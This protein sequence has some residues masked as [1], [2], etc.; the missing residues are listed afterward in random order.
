VKNGV[1]RVA[2]ESRCT[3]DDYAAHATL[4][5]LVRD[6]RDEARQLA[7]K[8]AGRAVWM[9]S[10]TAQG[11]GVAEMMPR[12]VALLGE[13]GVDARWAVMSAEPAFFA[14]TKTIHN[15]VHGTGDGTALGPNERALYEATSRRAADA[16]FGLVAPRDLLVVHDPQP[17]G[18]GAIVKRAL[19]LPAIWRCHIG[20][21]EETPETRAAWRFLQPWAEAYDRAVFSAP[22]FFRDFLVGRAVLMHPSIDP[23]DHKNRELAPTKLVGILA[24]A[25]LLQPTHPVLTAPFPAQA[26]RLRASDGELV[27]ALGDQEIG[28]PFRPT[29]VQISRWDRLKGFAPLI[30]G[31]CAL[32][33]RVTRTTD[34]RHRR[35]LEIARLILAGPEPAAIQDDP[36]ARAVLAELSAKLRALPPDLAADV[37][38]VVLPMA[39]RK[40]N[41]LMVNCLQRCATLVVQNS[42][43]EGF[44]LTVTEA[45]WKGVAVLGTRGTGIRQQLRDRL[46]G[47][48]LDDPTDPAEIA[49]TLDAMLANGKQRQA[50]GRNG[51]GRVYDGF[52]VFR[53]LRDWLR[54]LADAADRGAL[55]AR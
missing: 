20:H 35:R 33:Q 39:S 47:R 22:E 10:S 21:T 37:A 42:L 23:L 55:S 8:L 12:L 50:W 13:L 16:L 45:M 26:R 51:H 17:L 29:V 25:G 49:E 24:N 54:L 1:E 41:A 52:L 15:L 2:V 4:S 38:L 44:S 28:Q 5:P 30:D 53:Q 3:L 32:K 43:R 14:L 40:H 36:E 46:D 18:V 27:P 19:G 11:G 34:A 9:L 48:L 7:P 6:L 31:F